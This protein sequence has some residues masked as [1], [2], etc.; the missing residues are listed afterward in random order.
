MADFGGGELDAFR[1]EVR[2][3]LEA[4]YPAELRDGSAKTDPEA[5]WAGRKF[6]GSNDPQIVW[7]RRMA[8][9]GWTAPTWP[10]EYGGGGLTPAQARVLDQELSAGR[11]ANP[12]ASFG[13]WMLGPVLLEYATE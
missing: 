9:K 12:I 1:T 3:W 6:E 7:M 10:S 2:G 4:N 5:I 8:E 13:I 11:Y